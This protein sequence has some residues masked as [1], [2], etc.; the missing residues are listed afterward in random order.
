MTPEV[1]QL[2]KCYMRSGIVLE[3]TVIEW[4]S[5]V[6]LKSLTDETLM[7]IHHPVEDI[8][9]TKIML[10]IETSSAENTKTDTKEA[11]KEKLHQL[12]S[13]EDP[14]L[15]EKTVAELRG[16]VIAQDRK[17]ISDKTKEHFG[18]A[19]AGK[20]TKYSSFIP[21]KGK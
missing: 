3:G 4:A 9:L 1:D 15:R 8:I 6:V 7:I 16:M 5:E 20:T 2:V 17:I 19:G 18:S 14:E 11:I 13:L 12:Q 10:K 21:I